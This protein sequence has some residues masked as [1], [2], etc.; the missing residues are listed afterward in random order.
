VSA[1]VNALAAGLLFGLSL[2]VVIGAQNTYVLRQGLRREH[3]PTVV[4]ICAASD[5]VLI[6]AGVGGA[7]LAL[8]GR[9]ML[10]LAVRVAGA[11]FLFGYGALAA[12]RVLRASGLRADAAGAAASLPAVVATC[13]AFTWLNPAVYLDTVVLLGSVAN[14]HPGVQWWFGGGAAL[15]SLGWFLGLGYGA[16]LLGPLFRRAAAGRVLD[17]SVAVVMVATGLRVLLVR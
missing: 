16:R 12:R 3:V 15:G 2:I 13:L 14:S 10:L 1:S 7:G 17:G 9:P 11:L 5:A 4:A 8:D 6:A